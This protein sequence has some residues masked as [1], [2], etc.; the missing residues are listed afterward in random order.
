VRPR[1]AALSAAA[2]L[3]AVAIPASATTT[4]G[5]II[6]G[7]PA[8]YD[9]SPS[10]IEHGNIVQEWWCGG[11]NPSDPA[12]Y[13]DSIQYQE[14]NTSGTPLVT[15]RTVLSNGATGWDSRFTCNATV[16]KAPL[17]YGGTA[18]SYVMYYVGTA[19]VGGTDN[20]VGAAFS[21]DGI[22]WVR[23]GIVV[24]F[25][26]TGHGYY[27]VAQPSAY[28]DGSQVVLSWEMADQNAN[29]HWQAA[30]ADGVTFGAA[31]QISDAGLVSPTPQYMAY[32]NHVP[33]WGSI[34]YDKTN[35]R[36]YT[37]IDDGW[38]PAS[39]TAGTAVTGDW[40]MTLMATSDLFGGTWTALDT[41]DTGQTGDQTGGLGGL[42]RN[43][44]GSLYSPLLPSV[45]IEF[46]VSN[47]RLAW[48]ASGSTYGSNGAVTNWDLSQF[49]W[50]P[51]DPLRS[52]FRA[53]GADNIHITTTGWYDALAYPSPD[54]VNLGA[55]YEAPTGAATTA[56][57]SCKAF[58]SN[59]FWTTDPNCLG[60]F[61]VGL[62]GYG[63][64]TPAADRLPLYRCEVREVGDYVSTDPNC[65]GDYSYGLI[66]YSQAGP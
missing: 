49:T 37:V 11:R 28:W 25:T 4:T 63:Y 12:T 23:A 36:W 31:R 29:S 53:H 34:A 3:A 14:Y 56:I 39:T 61:V 32:A 13:H 38:R 9:Y 41:V 2:L 45:S 30:A 52:I 54:N 19:V 8:T 1:A 22:T 20:Q 40:G 47:P 33:S 18:Y 42:L 27:G 62:A 57:F 50:S 55:L 43:P 7:R 60:A 17:S 59:Y 16:I 15:E 65:G 10:F 35:G 6:A 21:S 48:N 26:D 64:S 46:N 24:P 51:G 44:D 5:P 66:A 58:S